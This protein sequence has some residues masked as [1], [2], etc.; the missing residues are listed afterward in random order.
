MSEGE[1]DGITCIAMARER[2]PHLR[3]VV[4]SEET[5][6]DYI[7]KALEAGAVAYVVKSAYPDDL[8]SAVRQAF[9]SSVYF[10]GTRPRT[11]PHQG[12]VRPETLDL[13]RREQEIL[14]LV[15]EG[16]SNAH[17]AKLLWVTEQTIKFHLS[18]IY[19]K[20]GVSNRT[21][22]AR[23]GP[24]ARTADRAVPARLRFSWRASPPPKGWRGAPPHHPLS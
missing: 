10:V 24:V 3:A 4:L 19:R 7:D 17:L 12:A 1:M 23:L 20:L 15:S 22:A 11:A 16:H 14:Q 2:V 8:A 13:T 5:S 6:S 18:N 9:G 21:E